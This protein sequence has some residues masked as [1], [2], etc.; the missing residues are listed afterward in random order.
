MFFLRV[1]S[2]LKT[3]KSTL[4]VLLFIILFFA[5]A[6]HYSLV[7]PTYGRALVSPGGPF[8]NDPSLSVKRIFT[9]LRYP[10]S[11][12]FL[13]ENDILVLEKNDGVVRRIVN[14]QMFKNPLLQASVDRTDERGLLGVAISNNLSRNIT[15]VFLYFTEF[16]RTFHS[17]GITLGNRLYRYELVGDKLIDP[18]LLLDLPANPGQSHDGGKIKIGPDGN[19]YVTVGDMQGS[20]N[21]T[22]FETKAQNYENGPNPDGRAGILRITQD[23]K[24]I[25][26]GLIG[27]TYPTNL[28]YAYGIKNSFGIAFD[29]ESEKLWD[30]ENGPTFGDE[31]NLVEPGFNSGWAKVQGIWNV[32]DKT[33]R[34]D[35]ISSLNPP[36]LV[37]FNGE[38][39][40]SE[41]EFTWL[42]SVA[43]TAITFLNSS[44][45]GKVYQHDMFV[46]DIK[47]GSIY[48]FKLNHD[49]TQLQLDGVL[50]DK[51]SNST[52][53][54]KD[55]IFGQGFGGITDLNIGPDGYLYVLTFDSVN[56][57]IY[58]VFPKN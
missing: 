4:A 41:P 53:E 54:N 21:A 58:K 28:Y 43:P 47:F 14:G 31:I 18:K 37:T 5:I 34:I 8:I 10:T 12:A 11:M 13:R 30:T 23:G 3:G 56:G 9:G 32:D 52:E 51:V 36:D 50:S 15:Y 55:L 57:T 29:P 20:F 48:H 6:A 22:N 39:K 19:L 44:K 2:Q 49:R 16:K 24:P 7:I 33:Q 42:D 35:G 17:T 40:Y 27:E 45:L 38:G 46:A 1:L 25:G 26:D